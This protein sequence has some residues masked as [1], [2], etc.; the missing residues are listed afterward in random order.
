MD[1]QQLCTRE[2]LRVVA[3]AAIICYPTQEGYA[4]D[5]TRH[6]QPDVTGINQYYC[7]NCLHDFVPE[8]N[9]ATAIE[10]AW[11]ETITHVEVAA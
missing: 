8:D 2:D 7:A 5:W 6:E 11:A 10:R 9:S 1:E 3:E 4:G